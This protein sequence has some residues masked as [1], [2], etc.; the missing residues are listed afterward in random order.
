VKITCMILVMLDLLATFCFQFCNLN[1][2]LK[3]YCIN[4]FQFYYKLD[5]LQTDEISNIVSLT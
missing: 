2:D 4:F 3:P 5:T 1:V